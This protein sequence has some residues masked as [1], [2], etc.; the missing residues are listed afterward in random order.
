ML[1]EFFFVRRVFVVGSA[2]GQAPTFLQVLSDPFKVG[3]VEIDAFNGMI[4]MI[5]LRGIRSRSK[6]RRRRVNKHR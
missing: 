4:F 3:D 2:I 1:L 5:L 6:H